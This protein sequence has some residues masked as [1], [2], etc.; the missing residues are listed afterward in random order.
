MNGKWALISTW[1][2]SERPVRD[3]AAMLRQG[4]D[5]E[6]VAEA[7]ASAVEDDAKVES[8]GYGGWPNIHGE[9][10]LDGAMMRGRDLAMGSVLG[11]EGFRSPVR[12]ARL[13]MNQ[14]RHHVL[15]DRGAAEFADSFGCERADML[16]PE[17]RVRWLDKLEE[18]KAQGT[19]VPNHDT[20]GVLVL[21]RSD[22]IVVA[23]S[24]SGQALKMR[25]RVGDSALV[26]SGFYA[27]NAVGA[28]AATGFGEDIMRGCLCF[29]AVERMRRGTPPKLAAEEAV[30]NL[31]ARLAGHGEVHNMALIC[32][33]RNGQV[34]G[35]ANHRGFFY[36]TAS[37]DRKP[38]L[39]E[40]ESC[41]T[42][43]VPISF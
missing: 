30:Q 20:V 4:I 24:T 21:D 36:A 33:D 9:M 34:G 13:V 40:V 1:P 37:D 16:S 15:I 11:L 25:G 12:V 3:G 27:D 17:A 8:V 39:V 42:P 10:S 19:D 38:A 35:A 26:G 22:D 2:F 18:W 23:M 28:A 14:C 5:A 43:P 6:S 32:L 7:V 41:V 29:D 31:H